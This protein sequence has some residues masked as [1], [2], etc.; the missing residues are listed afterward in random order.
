MCR[1]HI[2]GIFFFFLKKKSRS[3]ESKDNLQLKVRNLILSRRGLNVD[4]LLGCDS[5]KEYAILIEKQ[6]VLLERTDCV[7]QL[8]S[9][10]SP[11]YIKDCETPG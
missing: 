1:L 10:M 9:L 3:R 5:V 2:N 7:L 6:L 8:L 4:L 11:T